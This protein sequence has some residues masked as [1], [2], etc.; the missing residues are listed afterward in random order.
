MQIRFTMTLKDVVV[1]G[2][3]MDEFIIDWTA[4]A[5]PEEVLEISKEWISSRDQVAQKMVGL[6]KVGELSLVMDA[7]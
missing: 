7:A 2:E 5:E 3:K 4:N 1:N 6:S